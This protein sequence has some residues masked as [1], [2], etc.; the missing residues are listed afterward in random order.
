VSITYGRLTPH[1]LDKQGNDPYIE[2]GGRRYRITELVPR[3]DGGANYQAREVTESDPEPLEPQMPEPTP[4]VSVGGGVAVAHN[5]YVDPPLPE[6]RPFRPI[7]PTLA[8]WA[9][10]EGLWAGVGRIP[11]SAKAKYVETF[12]IEE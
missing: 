8:A 7:V 2:A 4:V 6:P 10:N 3:H 1:E 11:K 9:K 5:P 12:G